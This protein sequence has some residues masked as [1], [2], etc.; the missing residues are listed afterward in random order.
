MKKRARITRTQ[1]RAR[2]RGSPEPLLPRPRCGGERRVV[3]VLVFLIPLI[4]PLTDGIS[5]L[6]WGL[7]VPVYCRSVQRA[8]AR[9]LY[10]PQ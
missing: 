3:F 9:A 4:I 10:C 6:T 5:K 2:L 8:D 7:Y 1:G